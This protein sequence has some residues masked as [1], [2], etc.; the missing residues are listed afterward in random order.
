MKNPELHHAQEERTV[1]ARDIDFD[2]LFY[3]LADANVPLLLYGTGGAKTVQHLLSEIHDGESLLSVDAKGN[4]YREV[5]VLW[6][7]VFCKLSN[8]EIYTLREDRQEFQDGRVKRRNLDSSL[9]E[10]LKPGEDPQE[11]VGRVLAEELGIQS[12]T[13][14]TYFMSHDQT[15]LTPDTYPGLE[16]DYTF[17]KY[18]AIISEDDFE[19]EG[20]KEVHADK[21]NYYVWQRL[22]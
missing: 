18:A 7:D 22:F 11:A 14:A 20:Y 10:K 3:H 21:T 19:S 16:T 17:Y 6:L 5:E 9:G 8:S 4:I 1:L 2:T 12:S 15:T 13:E